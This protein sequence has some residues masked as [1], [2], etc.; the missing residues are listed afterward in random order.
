MIDTLNETFGISRHITFHEG[1]NEMPK[2]IIANKYATAEIYLHGAHITS[3]Q[4]HGA[5]QVLWTSEVAQ[6]EEGKA[7]RGGVPVI[8]PWFGDHPTDANK[9]AHGFARTQ[10]WEVSETLVLPSER[11]Q[12]KLK[13]G[14][15]EA[16]QA[17]WPHPFLLEL[18]VTVGPQLQ[19]D[20]IT[21]N[22]HSEGVEVSQALHTYFN[23]GDIDQVSVMGLSGRQYLDKVQGY[24]EFP[25]YGNIPFLEEVDRIYLNTSDE[26]I[27]V[28]EALDRKIH[29]DKL[30]SKSTV[31]WN[32]WLDKSKKMGDFPDEGYRTMLC[33]ETTNAAGDTRRISP[34]DEHVLTQLI[35]LG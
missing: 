1:N 32:P 29:V 4:P 2:A 9:P 14:Q 18:H 27:I 12:I 7:I 20:L 24:K 13:L 10:Q 31:V 25:Q 5:E 11:T 19:I 26:C 28:D 23:V 34:R 22:H 30:G 16:T 8:W 33:V 6:F 21:H 15:S 17:L 3:F 35:R